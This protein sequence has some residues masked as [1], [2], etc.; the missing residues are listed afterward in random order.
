MVEQALKSI[1]ADK[2]PWPSGVTSDFIKAAGATGVKRLIQVCESIEK[3]GELPQQWAKGYKIP[4][5][6]GEGDVLMVDKHR[7]LSFWNR[8]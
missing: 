5:Y 7:G 1:K 4:V 3:E 6:K 2:V 8:I